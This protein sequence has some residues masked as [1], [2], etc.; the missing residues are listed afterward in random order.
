MTGNSLSDRRRRAVARRASR[1][2]RGGEHAQGLGARRN[3][4]DEHGRKDARMG[5]RDRRRGCE[6][7]LPN[8]AS[9]GRAIRPR[10]FAC[11][12]RGH[13]QPDAARDRH[14]LSAHAGAARR[15]GLPHRLRRQARAAHRLFRHAEARRRSGRHPDPQ[16]PRQLATVSALDFEWDATRPTAVAA[17]TALFSDSDPDGAVGDTSDSGLKNA[18]RR[19]ISRP[20]P[21]SPDHG[22][23]DGSGRQCRRSHLARQGAAARGGLVRALRR[24]A[25]ADRVGVVLRPGM[26]LP[27]PASARCSPARGSSGAFVTNS[28]RKDT[29]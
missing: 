22:D 10:R 24:E 21:A 18:E 20:S 16:R 14:R 2:P 25:D 19:R 29:R 13:S 23:A 28:R 3:L 1:R 9:S 17:R 5:R 26:L 12:H 8:T 6:H 7:V 27:S 15:Q 11:A 4:V